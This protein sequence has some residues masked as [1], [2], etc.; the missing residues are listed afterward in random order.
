MYK[1]PEKYRV[2]LEKVLKYYAW[3]IPIRHNN[4]FLKREEI[5]K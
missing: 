1:L 3:S 2:K 4:N 5:V